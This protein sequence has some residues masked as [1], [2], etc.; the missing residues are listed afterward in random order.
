MLLNLGPADGL[1][2]IEDAPPLGERAAVMDR[3]RAVIPGI[4]FDARG[5]GVFNGEHSTVTIDLGPDDPV[6]TAVAAAEGADGLAALRQLLDISGWRAYSPKSGA[7][8]DAE[9]LV[10]TPLT[11]TS[12]S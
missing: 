4:E 1:P 10:P 3:V 2:Q 8:V 7:F 9:A 5:R 12:G 6:Q 11:S